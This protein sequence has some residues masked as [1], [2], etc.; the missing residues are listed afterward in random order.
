MEKLEEDSNQLQYTTC[1]SPIMHLICSK[2]FS[3]GHL[4]DD[5]FHY[6]DQNSSGLCFIVYIKD[7]VI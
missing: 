5:V 7:F 2:S 4:H 3:I 6:Y 1:T